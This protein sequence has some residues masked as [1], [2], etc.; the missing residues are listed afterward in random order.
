MKQYFLMFLTLSI[1]SLNATEINQKDFPLI[2]P[3]SVEEA[4]DNSFVDSDGDGIEDRNDK[5]QETVFNVKV[6]AFGC[7]ILKDNDGDGISN[8]DDKCPNSKAGVVVNK[9]GCEPDEDKDGVADAIDECPDTS[10]DFVVD[11][12]GCPKTTIL[13]INFEPAKYKILPS[14]FDKVQEFANFLKENMGYQVII[15]GYTDSINTKGNNK[16]LS[17]NRA[18]AV[19]NALI[20]HGIK[21]TRITAIGMGSKN[22]IADNDTMEGRAKNRRIEVELLQ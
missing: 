20:E 1:F 13:K 21:L 16:K 17:Q 12:V 3:I 4:E 9:E 22:P 14:S 15:Y 18:N 11:N 5:C 10:G 19:M 2:Q 6:D 7:K 8:R